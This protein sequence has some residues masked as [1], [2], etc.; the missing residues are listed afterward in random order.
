MSRG[1]CR[2]Y[3]QSPELEGH[4]VLLVPNCWSI[5]GHVEE[6]HLSCSGEGSAQLC[7]SSQLPR[8]FIEECWSFLSALE[9][10]KAGNSSTDSQG[11]KWIFP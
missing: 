2:E 7:L 5:H 9:A 6:K 4:V 8:E 11:K 10:T 3:R 1:E